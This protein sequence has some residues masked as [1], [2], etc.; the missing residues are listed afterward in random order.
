ME[1][2]MDIAKAWLSTSITEKRSQPESNE[3]ISETMAVLSKKCQNFRAAI[4]THIKV[5]IQNIIYI[6][7]KVY[8]NLK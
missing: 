8:Y 6:L 3:S 1:F 4:P 2:K 5:S 7:C